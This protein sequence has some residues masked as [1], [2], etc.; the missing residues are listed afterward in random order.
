MNFYP[1][2]TPKT[3]HIVT[4][5]KRYYDDYLT[6]LNLFKKYCLVI[7]IDNNGTREVKEVIDECACCMSKQPNVLVKHLFNQGCERI[8]RFCFDCVTEWLY[9][10]NESCMLCREKIDEFR[11]FLHRKETLMT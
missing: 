6:T 11:I 2:F 8:V 7:A 1:S 3:K 5:K 9:E 10:G 4:I